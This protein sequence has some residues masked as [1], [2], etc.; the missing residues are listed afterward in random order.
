MINN[1]YKIIAM[2]I[3]VF[4]QYTRSEDYLVNYRGHLM[5]TFANMQL[6]A[7]ANGFFQ[8]ELDF[9]FVQRAVCHIADVKALEHVPA[10]NTEDDCMVIMTIQKFSRP[11]NIKFI[12]EL[13]S[14]KYTQQEIAD[15]VGVSLRSAQRWATGIDP[16]DPEIM[17]KLIDMFLDSEAPNKVG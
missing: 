3:G 5:A 15:A 14:K 4:S 10:L 9:Q 11:M 7:I 8:N 17:G 12:M 1:D 13:L 16:K 2:C 6:K